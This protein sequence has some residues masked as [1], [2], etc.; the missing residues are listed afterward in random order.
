MTLWETVWEQVRKE[1]P[2]PEPHQ[3]TWGGFV[4]AAVTATFIVAVAFPIKL[5]AEIFKTIDLSDKPDRRAEAV[6]LFREAHSLALDLPSKS[7]FARSVLEPLTL[8]TALHDA[9]HSALRQLYAENMP[10]ETPVIPDD[11][12]GLVD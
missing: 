5:V 4:G 3:R 10:L 12:D 8:P 2:R 11:L 6:A 9:W 1:M 7:E